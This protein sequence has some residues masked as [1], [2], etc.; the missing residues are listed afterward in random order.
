M[1]AAIKKVKEISHS[2]LK[3]NETYLSFVILYS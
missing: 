3:K 1:D 2:F